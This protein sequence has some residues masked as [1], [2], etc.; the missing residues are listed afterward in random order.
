[1]AIVI[2]SIYSFIIPLVGGRNV[3]VKIVGKPLIVS[4][5]PRKE[6][7]GVSSSSYEGR[8]RLSPAK[9]A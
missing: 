6:R 2:C 8:S 3:P 1:M 5:V 7:T 4:A 9:I